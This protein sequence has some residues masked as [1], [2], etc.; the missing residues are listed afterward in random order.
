MRTQRYSPG[1]ISDKLKSTAIGPEFLQLTESRSKG[2]PLFDGIFGRYLANFVADRFAL[3]ALKLPSSRLFGSG[4]PDP[5]S[6]S[7][8]RNSTLWRFMLTR[9][10]FSS[11]PQIALFEIAGVFT[12]STRDSPGRSN[13]TSEA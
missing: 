10:A 8:W 6:L 7:R 5:E 3:P 12:N 2:F 9:E 13:E 4:E 11:L 1:V